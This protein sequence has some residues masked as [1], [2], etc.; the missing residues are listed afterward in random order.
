MVATASETQGPTPAPLK[1]RTRLNPARRKSAKSQGECQSTTTA[2]AAAA[3]GTAMEKSSQAQDRAKAS[4]NEATNAQPVSEQSSTTAGQQKAGS[5]SSKKDTTALAK[6]TDPKN[7]N[8]TSKPG[9][10]G[11]T[12]ST[13]KSGPLALAA[14]AMVTGGLAGCAAGAAVI[15]GAGLWNKFAGADS[16]I[17]AARTAKLC[18]DNLI[19]EIITSLKAGTYSAPEALDMLRRTT[20]AYASTIPGGAPFV[21][22]LFREIDMVRKQRG[23]EV[24]K[25]IAEAYV[26]LSKAGKRGASTAELHA[27]VIRNLVKLSSF[28][29]KATQDI[30]ARNPNLSPFRERAV[31][32]LQPPPPKSKVPTV[33][34][35]MA[36]Q[37]KPAA[38]A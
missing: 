32:A 38:K 18:L 17:L 36:V 34:I 5:A 21:E 16:A 28:A 2:A 37:H 30:V 11:K 35:N 9:V 15:L 12:N 22:R 13:P 27:I 4:K 7:P 29:E 6:Q 8:G 25:V 10:A 1:K 19:E 33:K 24:D 31:R 14:P 23:R 20:L 26:D 3:A